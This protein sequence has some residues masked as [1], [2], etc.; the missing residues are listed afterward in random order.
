MNVINWS[1]PFLLKNN[2]IGC[3]TCTNLWIM[4][5]HVGHLDR[6]VHGIT[7]EEILNN[8]DEN[9]TP[10]ESLV[11]P[12]ITLT[13]AL[14]RRNLATFKNLAQQKLQIQSG[15]SHQAST[16]RSDFLKQQTYPMFIQ[17][18]RANLKDPDIHI[19]FFDTES[20]IGQLEW[21][22]LFN[23]HH[24]YYWCNLVYNSSR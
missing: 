2:I 15:T 22:I 3:R 20:L 21:S 24:N 17:G 8:C 12:N 4:L 18:I 10:M 5:I 7:A 6:V 14:K 11:N 13:Q 1:V 9:A 23:I 19:L 16:H